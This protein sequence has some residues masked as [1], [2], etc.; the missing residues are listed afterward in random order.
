[1][2]E[3]SHSASSTEDAEGR[4]STD[5]ITLELLELE[6]PFLPERDAGIEDISEDEEGKMEEG[7]IMKEST[8]LSAA[9]SAVVPGAG[10]PTV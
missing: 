6:E 9:G 4:E 5:E 2:A 7:E 8:E 10:C 3:T 1:M